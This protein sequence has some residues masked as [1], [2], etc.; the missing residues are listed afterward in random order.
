[1]TS[2]RPMASITNINGINFIHHTKSPL[3]CRC[4]PP[5]SHLLKINIIIIVIVM[6]VRIVFW[7]QHRA[8]D[9]LIVSATQKL[10]WNHFLCLLMLS[11]M[12][13][14]VDTLVT[15]LEFLPSPSLFNIFASRGQSGWNCSNGRPFT[16]T[17]E[18]G[19]L[20]ANNGPLNLCIMA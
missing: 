7:S 4:P 8:V 5:P 1:M 10:H 15:A 14:T 20:E 3:H 2:L 16:A 9:L 11:S 6:V 13:V 17:G 12:H 18:G 19:L